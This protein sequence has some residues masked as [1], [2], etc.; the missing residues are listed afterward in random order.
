MEIIPHDTLLIIARKAGNHR[1]TA[2][3]NYSSDKSEVYSITGKDIV[4]GKDVNYV[5]L[6]QGA[7]SIIYE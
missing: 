6:T 1:I 7:Y 2:I 5:T 3:I 4:N